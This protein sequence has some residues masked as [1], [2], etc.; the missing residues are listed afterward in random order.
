MRDVVPTAQC[1]VIAPLLG[2]PRSEH[3]S[4]AP[5]RSSV[6]LGPRLRL[7]G[8]VARG[9][10][11]APWRENAPLSLPGEAEPQ[12][13]GSPA[14]R[15]PS[16][17]CFARTAAESLRLCT[18]RPTAAITRRTEQGQRTPL[19][20]YHFHARRPRSC[21]YG[22]HTRARG[23]GVQSRP[24]SSLDICSTAEPHPL[25]SQDFR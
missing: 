11:T 12:G 20:R 24:G 16:R 9:H 1:R 8:Q 6:R 7:P 23:A 10:N 14:Q 18:P 3:P 15:P 19:S 21:K 2:P 5:G 22:V 13:A 17:S 25:C 4:A